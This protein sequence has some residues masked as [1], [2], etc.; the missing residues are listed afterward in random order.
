MRAPVQLRMPCS[1]AQLCRLSY[2]RP[3]DCCAAIWEKIGMTDNGNTGVGRLGIR[4]M[5]FGEGLHGNDP[6]PPM[7]PAMSP[8]MGGRVHAVLSILMTQ[9]AGIFRCGCQLRHCQRRS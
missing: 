9:I 1:L 7:S 3:L 2:T 8:A 6:R 5:Q 4:P